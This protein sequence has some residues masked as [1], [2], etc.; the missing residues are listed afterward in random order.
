M[1]VRGEHHTAQTSV[2]VLTV[3]LII[4]AVGLNDSPHLLVERYWLK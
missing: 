1:G 4:G 2:I 3:V